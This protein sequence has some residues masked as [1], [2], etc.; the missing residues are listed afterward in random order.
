[1]KDSKTPTE[2][3]RTTEDR[4]SLMLIR[5][6]AC[7]R[8]ISRKARACPHCGHPKMRKV[9]AIVIAMAIMFLLF[10]KE[11]HDVIPIPDPVDFI[12][13]RVVGTP[14]TGTPQTGRL[15]K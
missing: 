8:E 11:I 14:Q 6:Q 4:S 15:L 5:C 9:R 2:A 1:V 3:E 10:H 12:L 13:H 7:D